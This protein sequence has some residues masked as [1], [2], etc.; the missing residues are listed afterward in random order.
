MKRPLFGQ[1]FSYDG[2]GYQPPPMQHQK[3]SL[4]PMP[5]REQSKDHWMP[6]RHLKE[7]D[8]SPGTRGSYDQSQDPGPSSSRTSGEGNPPFRV[9]HSYNSPA[10]KGIPIWG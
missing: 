8:P 5:S 7:R 10:Y 9:L 4:A 1:R 6:N 2:H 3:S